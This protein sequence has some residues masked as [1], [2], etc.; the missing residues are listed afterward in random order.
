MNEKHFIDLEDE[1]EL[2]RT[3]RSVYKHEGMLGVYTVMGELAASLHVVAE[4]AQELLSEEEKGKK[5]S[6]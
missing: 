3:I 4:L 2:R 6:F 5:S 1:I